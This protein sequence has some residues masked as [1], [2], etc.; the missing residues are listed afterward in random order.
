[1]LTLQNHV[2]GEELA[3]TIQ[4]IVP[5]PLFILFYTLSRDNVLIPVLRH[6]LTE[7][8]ENKVYGDNFEDALRVAV[9]KIIG[10]SHLSQTEANVF[11]KELAPKMLN[12]VKE[13]AQKLQ[14]MEWKWK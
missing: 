10:E 1:M 12:T 5:R 4:Y 7:L 14:S 9:E 2:P 13:K 3:V 11:W 6:V 8:G